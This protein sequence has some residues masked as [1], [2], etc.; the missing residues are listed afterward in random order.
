MEIK[1]LNDKIQGLVNIRKQVEEAELIYKGLKNTKDLIQSELVEALKENDLK[2]WKIASTGEN[3]II[4][5]R[6]SIGITNQVLAF[7]FAKENNCVDEK[8]N[9]DNLKKV[10]NNLE[11]TPSGFEVKETSYLSI[12]KPKEDDISTK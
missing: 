7:S 1:Q 10:I 6:K 11:E 9:K 2:S 8:I 4:A 5:K 12:K 3:A